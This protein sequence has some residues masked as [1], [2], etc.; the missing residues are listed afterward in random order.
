MALGINKSKELIAHYMNAN[1]P[2]FVWGKPGIGKTKMIN[3]I[4]EANDMNTKVFTANIYENVDLRGLPAIDRDAKGN[5]VRAK[6]LTPAMLPDDKRDGKRGI[7]FLDDV[8]T[9]PPSMQAPLFGLALER[10]IGD[11]RLGDGW[12]VIAAS[13]YT[14]DRAG[15]SRINLALANRFAHVEVE[16]NKDDFEVWALDNDVPTE[17]IAFIRFR[18]Q[19]LHM[20]DGIGQTGAF[21]SP[22]QWERFGYVFKN[23]N[24]SET[25]LL[26][27]ACQGMLGLQAAT[28]FTAFTAIINKLPNI[29][30]ILKS[31]LTVP[32][33]DDMSARYAVATALAKNMKDVTASTA[34]KLTSAITYMERIS[35]EFEVLFITDAKRANNKIT[36]MRPF[37]DWC[38]KNSHLMF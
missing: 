8:L 26:M 14:T 33:P 32:V 15:A 18:P 35:P 7:L 12:H 13:N 29:N 27:N 37:V 34:S 24:T 36:T 31:P 23:L 9:A 22:R 17:I 30:D 1:L 38:A 25:A 19:Y 6:W 4:A 10:R 5:A 3:Q 28:E 2:V 11:Y 21:P 20:T 16:S